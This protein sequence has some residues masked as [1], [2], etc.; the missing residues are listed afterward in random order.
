ME[1]LCGPADWYSPW[2]VPRRVASLNID[3]ISIHTPLA[4]SDNVKLIGNVERLYFYPRSP[5]GERQQKQINLSP[6][7]A[8]K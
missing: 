7:F 3:F 1:L 4:G 5:R 8:W 6:I 2:G